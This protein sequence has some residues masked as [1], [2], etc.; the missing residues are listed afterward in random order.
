MEVEGRVTNIT[1]AGAFIA[2][3]AQ[4]DGLL[5]NASCRARGWDRDLRVGDE[6]TGLVVGLIDLQKNRVTL[7]FAGGVAAP[8]S[9]GGMAGRGKAA[10]GEGKRNAA[11]ENPGKIAATVLRV[12]D[13]VSGC[14]TAV[15]VRGA[16]VDVG[17][18]SDAWLPDGPGAADVRTL[19]VNARLDELVVDG[20]DRRSGCPT[21]RMSGSQ[22]AADRT[23][24]CS[25]GR[26]RPQDG[27][28]EEEARGQS[29]AWKATNRSFSSTW[30]EDGT[31]GTFG[32]DER[33]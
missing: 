3:G 23:A 19:R 11:G 32:R 22:A 12:G 6:I 20:F 21:L 4:K 1:H 14:V 18:S 31:G 10:K 33:D 30:M 24:A 7:H 26:T 28:E 2:F 15:T 17:A 13:P 27:R 9:S 8:A 25:P 5:S 16:S 29:A